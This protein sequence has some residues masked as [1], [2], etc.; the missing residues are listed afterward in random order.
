MDDFSFSVRF[1]NTFKKGLVEGGRI[2]WFCEIKRD[3]GVEEE[4]KDRIQYNEIGRVE[5]RW[6]I[7]YRF[8]GNI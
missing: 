2:M 7:V 8:S 4:I 1:W 3:S 6:D 5:R